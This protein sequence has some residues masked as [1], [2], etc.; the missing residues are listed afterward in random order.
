MS[1]C[2]Q[3]PP[4][5]HHVNFSP[6]KERDQIQHVSVLDSD[7]RPVATCDGCHD[8]IRTPVWAFKYFMESLWNLLSKGSGLMSISSR[9][10]LQSSI[11]YRDLFSPRCWVTRSKVFLVGVHVRTHMNIR[12]AHVLVDWLRFISHGHGDVKLIMWAHVRHE[13]E[14]T[15]HEMMTSHYT[16]CTLCPKT[17]DRRMYSRCE[18]TYLGAIKRCTVTG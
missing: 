2:S 18:P 6:R 4:P 14:L 8:F 13:T 16:I 10:R 1:K 9:S 12:L 7:C 3:R 15:Q 17:W 5:G 11:Y